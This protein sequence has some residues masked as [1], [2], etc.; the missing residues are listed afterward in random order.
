MQR[1]KDLSLAAWGT[2]ATIVVSALT[3]A[4]FLLGI[5]GSIGTDSDPTSGSGSEVQSVKGFAEDMMHNFFGGN[6]AAIWADFHPAIKEILPEDR[7][8]E[9]EQRAG[10][11]RAFPRPSLQGH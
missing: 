4:T 6:Y 9:C 3:V 7:Y 11:A 10:K 2:V 5:V 1:L 8:I